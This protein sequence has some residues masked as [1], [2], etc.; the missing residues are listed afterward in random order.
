MNAI[1]KVISLLPALISAIKALEDAIPGAGRGEAKLAALR[2]ILSAADGTV[3]AIWPTIE[4]VVAVVVGL[5]NREGGFKK[6][7]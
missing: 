6:D 1:L 3:A 7:A 2:E 5:L 4:K